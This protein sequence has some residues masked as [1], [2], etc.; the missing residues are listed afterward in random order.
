MFIS[1]LEPGGDPAPINL[2]TALP[3]VILSPMPVAV[4][5]AHLGEEIAVQE[6]GIQD[7]VHTDQALS[8]AK[9]RIPRF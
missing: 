8:S 9:N 7:G 2:S 3:T 4:V 6:P 1:G 5:D